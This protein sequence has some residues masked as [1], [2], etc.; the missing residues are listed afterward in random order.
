[1]KKLTAYFR[2]AWMEL[3][4]VSWPTK[5]QTKEMTILVLIIALIWATYAGVLDWAFSHLIALVMS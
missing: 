2:D 4:K 1:M 5:A 3:K